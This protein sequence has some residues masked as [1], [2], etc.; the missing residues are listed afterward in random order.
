MTDERLLFIGSDYGIGAGGIPLLGN[1]NFHEAN[2]IICSPMT[3]A[4]ELAKL[5]QIVPQRTYASMLERLTSLGQWVEQGHTLVLIGA[6]TVPFSY[7]DAGNVGRSIRLEEIPPF[8]GVQFVA[9]SGTR[10]EYC[11]P[12]NLQVAFR[13][14]I[15]RMK[16]ECLLDGAD[17][18]PLLRVAA[19]TMGTNQVINWR[20]SQAW[21]GPHTL[22][23]AI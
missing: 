5:G 12:S 13:N 1:H 17:L 8:A 18:T 3:L 15:P 7:V 16:Y 20:L 9:A 2:F 14:L 21:A 23:S 4:G 11:G 6:N 10:V 19:A 22:H